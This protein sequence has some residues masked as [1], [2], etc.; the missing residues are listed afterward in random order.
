MIGVNYR[1]PIIYTYICMALFAILYV[2][3]KVKQVVD[4]D[5]Q[6]INELRLELE[7]NELKLIELETEHERVYQ[8]TLEQA[9]TIDELNTMIEEKKAQPVAYTVDRNTVVTNK[10][11]PLDCI[12]DV[13]FTEIGNQYS[14]DLGFAYAVWQL[15]TGHGKS[16]VWLTRNNPAGIRLNGEYQ[17]FN[18]V[19]DGYH[20][21]FGLLENYVANGRTTI[22]EIRDLWSETD[23]TSLIVTMWND[24][25]T[26]GL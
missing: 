11:T 23:D 24:L 18:S 19:Q 21:F 12:S 2:G 4:S 13:Q 6:Q 7:T 8:L 15:E 22:S 16:E 20:A 9:S 17:H 26:K 10:I 25:L 5:K 3:I 14:I 1:K